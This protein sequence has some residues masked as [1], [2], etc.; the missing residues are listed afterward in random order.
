MFD[1][2]ET[3]EQKPKPERTHEDI[4]ESN[5]LL[6]EIY[7]FSSTQETDDE[8]QETAPDGMD[9]A[10][11][12]PT[13]MSKV[14]GAMSYDARNQIGENRSERHQELRGYLVDTT[15]GDSPQTHAHDEDVRDQTEAVRSLID[16][17]G[18]EHVDEASV[19]AR[20]IAQDIENTVDGKVPTENGHMTTG[21]MNTVRRTAIAT[22]VLQG[23]QDGNTEMLNRL[24]DS[25]ARRVISY[26]QSINEHGG[27]DQVANNDLEYLGRKIE[28]GEVSE[29]SGEMVSFVGEDGQI[30]QVEKSNRARSLADAWMNGNWNE[31]KD[32]DHATRD[33]VYYYLETARERENLDDPDVRQK[34]MSKIAQMITM[35]QHDSDREKAGAQ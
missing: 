1:T 6:G 22:E 28:E 32:V 16:S 30:H 15:N 20:K 11:A 18:G 14:E 26:E 23:I 5:R 33:K 2:H 19:E 35:D 4:A 24:D 8:V 25:T 7:N 12:R 3:L 17:L 29:G 9:I 21:D 13:D 34:V 27:A 31:G 10:P